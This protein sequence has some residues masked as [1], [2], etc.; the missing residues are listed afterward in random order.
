MFYSC[1]CNRRFGGTSCCNLRDIHLEDDTVPQLRKPCL[2]NC[3][4]K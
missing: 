3:G 1:R 4:L 2:F